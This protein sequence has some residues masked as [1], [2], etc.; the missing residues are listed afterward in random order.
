M[1]TPVSLAGREG[2]F[3]KGLRKDEKT[4][5]SFFGTFLR[6]GPLYVFRRLFLQCQEA[7]NKYL[8]GFLV[9]PSQSGLHGVAE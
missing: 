7:M 5:G 1:V 8:G 6:D 4:F 2:W 9:P 3:V